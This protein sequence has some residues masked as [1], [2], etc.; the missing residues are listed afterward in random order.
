MHRCAG[1]VGN[2][3]PLIVQVDL[4]RATGELPTNLD[5]A[6]ER[7][8]DIQY[9]AHVLPLCNPRK[10]DVQSNKTASTR[11]YQTCAF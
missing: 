1:G 11:L 7:A 9:F 8:K 10:G 4:F 3:S 6:L 5:Q 2:A